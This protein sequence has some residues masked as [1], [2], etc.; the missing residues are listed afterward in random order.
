MVFFALRLILRFLRLDPPFL[1]AKG[2]SEDKLFHMLFFTGAAGAAAGI[3]GEGIAGAG[4]AGA[5]I[6]GAGAAGV[7]GGVGGGAD[8]LVYR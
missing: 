6:A 7:V 3:A 5:G 1:A 8:I 2:F 4:I